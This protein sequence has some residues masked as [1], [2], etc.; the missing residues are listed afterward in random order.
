MKTI[1]TVIALAVLSGCAARS[2]VRLS[3]G[4]QEKFPAHAGPVCMLKSPL[5]VGV[6]YSIIG[7]IDSSKRTYGSV[8]ELIPL[9]AADARSVGADAIVNLDTGQKFGLLAWSRPVGGGM[10][11]KLKDPAGFNC[12]ANGGELR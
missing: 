1:C 11:V 2:T 6:G 8:S 7:K 4:L 3:E 5:P 10:A 12:L 9:M